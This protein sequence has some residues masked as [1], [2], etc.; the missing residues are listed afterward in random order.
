M[1]VVKIKKQ[2]PQCVI[3]RR[4]RFKN[5]KNSLEVTQFENKINQLEKDQADID[6]IKKN[7]KGFKKNNKLVLQTQQRFKSEGHDVF[8]EEIK[9]IALSLNDDKTLQSFRK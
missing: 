5:Y 1:T 7:H 9:K 8:T 6:S 3:K 2:K 4:R